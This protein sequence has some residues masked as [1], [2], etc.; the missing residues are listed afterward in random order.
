MTPKYAKLIFFDYQQSKRQKNILFN[1]HKRNHITYICRK[2]KKDKMQDWKDA[3][4]SLIQNDES[5]QLTEQEKKEMEDKEKKKVQNLGIKIDKKGRSGKVAT[6][7]Y[8]FEGSEDEL[9]DFAKRLKTR[10]GIGGST[11]DGEIL[12]QGDLREKLGKILKEE[13]H[14]VKRMN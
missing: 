10:L 5:L 11:R 4:S 1:N 2:Q 12:L 3:L 14:K 13:G 7:I 8:G 9:D 6:I